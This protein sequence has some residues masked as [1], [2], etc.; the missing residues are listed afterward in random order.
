RIVSTIK[1][2]NAPRDLF[3]NGDKLAVFGDYYNLDYFRKIS[4]T[5]RYGMT[6]F[7]IYDIS[8]KEN[9]KLVENYKFEGSYFRARMKGNYVYYVVNSRP[10]YRIVEPLPII[11]RGEEKIIMPPTDVYYF[12]I[13]YRNPHLLTVHAINIKNPDEISSKSVLVEYGE[14]M[15]MSHDNIYLTYAKQISEWDIQKRII[16]KLLEN[17]LTDEDR[18]LIEKIKQTDNDVLSKSEKDAKI[19]E[20]YQSY[21]SVLSQKEQDELQGRAETLVKEELSKYKYFEY[22]IINKLSYDNGK[23]EVVANGKVPGHVINQ[24]SMDEYDNIFRIATTVNP[25][26]SRFGEARTE[27]Q[28]NI[29]A[30]DSDIRIIGKLEGLAKGERIYSTRFMGDKLYMVTFRQVDPFFVIDLSDPRNIKDLGKLKIPGFSRYLH[31]YDE[32]TI[33]GIGQD[34]TETGRTKGLK[35]SL[36]DVSDVSN[37]KEIAKFVTDE[38]YATSTALYNH[39]AFLLSKEKELLVIPAYSSG[40]YRGDGTKYN[41]AFVFH[42]TK[43]EI[44]LRGLIDHSR[45]SDNFWQPQVERSLYINE[46]LYTKSPSLLRINKIEDLTPV[47]DIELK[48]GT[49]GN[50]PVY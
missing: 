23:M 11:L 6:F 18:A 44:K 47:K 31:P 17:K 22:T 29:Y 43:N 42:I 12:N 1:F 14:N 9:P 39:H 50:I 30:L 21:A 36:F 15:Y 16:M 32:N 49:T 10:N 24:F 37:P 46:L 48:T 20:I 38:R 3:I 41:G 19:F 33:I 7:D 34:T 8:D 35:I 26:W 13:P 2:E 28:N 4:F 25:R 40:G 45:G 5:P 27:S